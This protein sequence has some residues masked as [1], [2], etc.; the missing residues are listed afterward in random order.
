[1]GRKEP[2]A[3]QVLWKPGAVCNVLTFSLLFSAGVE[4]YAR[5]LYA[6]I[7]TVALAGGRHVKS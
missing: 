4:I 5:S 7:L 3:V 2:A 6:I 1:M